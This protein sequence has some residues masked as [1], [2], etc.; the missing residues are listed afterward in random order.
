VAK[1]EASEEV[2]KSLKPAHKKPIFEGDELNDYEMPGGV[3][4]VAEDGL[5]PYLKNC[6]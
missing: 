5:F 4:T 6:L 3:A 1:E 2:P